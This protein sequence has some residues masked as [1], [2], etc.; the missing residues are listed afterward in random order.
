MKRLHGTP[1]DSLLL[2]TRRV[3]T[4]KAEQARICNVLLSSP[5]LGDEL[6]TV[7]L[8]SYAPLWQVLNEDCLPRVLSHGDAWLGNARVSNGQFTFFDLEWACI[9]PPGLDLGTAAFHLNR[10]GPGLTPYGQAM[11]EGYAKDTGTII[12]SGYLEA[13]TRLRALWS[14]TFLIGNRLLTAELLSAAIKRTLA[15]G[16]S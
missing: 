2:D 16:F 13:Y 14:F 4:A 11:T 10:D 6:A 1:L 9:A 5:L 3:W 15:Y 7:V 8:K 12:D